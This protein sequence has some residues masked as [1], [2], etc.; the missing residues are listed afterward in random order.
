MFL[1]INMSLCHLLVP[2]NCQ[3]GKITANEFCISKNKFRT[4]QMLETR[5]AQMLIPM[6]AAILIAYAYN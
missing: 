2:T 5:C 1:F 6:L 3:S 4:N